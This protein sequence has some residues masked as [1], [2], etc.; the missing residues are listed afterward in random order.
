MFVDL[1]QMTEPFFEVRIGPP[2]SKRADLTLLDN[3]IA[4]YIVNFEYS[5]VVNGGKD[6]AS[7][8][9]LVF[10]EPDGF[11]G[12]L[13]DL[14]LSN[15]SIRFFDAESVSEGKI[16]Q[17]D[18]PQIIS[19][20][21]SLDS[22]SKKQSEQKR[23]ETLKKFKKQSKPTF[24]FQERN[25]IEVSWGYRNPVD[26]KRLR[27]RTVRGEILTITYRASEASLG[28]IEVQAT[29]YGSSEM[30]KLYVK[31]GINF[32]RKKVKELL[33]GN[34]SDDSDRADTAPARA[35]DVFRAVALKLLPNTISRIEL[36]DEELKFDEQ[37]ATSSRSIAKGMNFH[38]FLKELAE[39]V[40][41]HYFVST[42]V[43]EGRIVNVIN[44]V[45][46]SLAEAKSKFHFMWMSGLG[47]RGAD[48]QDTDETVF[49][50]IKDL[51]LQ[52]Y[53]V[54]G[55]GAA[56]SGI[57]SKSKLSIGDSAE[58]SVRF[59]AHSKQKEAE[60]LTGDS[61]KRVNP[62]EVLTTSPDA[63]ANTNSTGASVYNPSSDPK[64]HV[65]V[66]SR[67]AGRMDKSLRLAF[68][69]VGIPQLR[70]QMIQLSN[71]GKRYSGMYYLLSVKHVIDPNSGY[72][73]HVVG[74]SNAISAGGVSVDKPQGV[75][76]DSGKGAKIDWVAEDGVRRKV[77]FEDL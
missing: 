14:A 29:D 62:Q 26:D 66:A 76:T 38:L 16:P 27:P 73:C 20:T 69:T 22:D 32:T 49:N 47:G 65:N 71:V 56:S 39:K 19:G 37:E 60:K 3:T 12:T 46:R 45:S 64:D 74:E 10:E 11:P 40:H 41:A 9:K 44:L 70:P 77:S 34:L 72:I 28:T 50:T 55:S 6:A 59:T 35:D 15:G 48:F 33:D 67:Y 52:L 2:G 54:G 36:T 18:V 43:V 75:K 58:F 7:S 5:E 68:S 51:D 4:R 13:L 61:F 25:I 17:D 8:I 24:L 21:N 57:D 53:P 31:E 23:I 63:K 42:D 30:S 1:K